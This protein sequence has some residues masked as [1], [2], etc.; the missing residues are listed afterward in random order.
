MLLALIP[1]T[2][3]DWED[4]LIVS[5]L[6]QTKM[7]Y[8]SKRTVQFMVHLRILPGRSFQSILNHVKYMARKRMFFGAFK[9]NA[10]VETFCKVDAGV[11]AEAGDYHKI[12]SVPTA[13]QHLAS[14]FGGVAEL[15]DEIIKLKWWQ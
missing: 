14:A 5:F 10:A 11:L 9:L 4:T 1:G 6:L 8:T 12:S 3:D 7:K 2:F 13:F 15:F